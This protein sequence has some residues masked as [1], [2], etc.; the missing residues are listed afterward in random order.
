MK[1]PSL[2][3]QSL[4]QISFLMSVLWVGHCGTT[5]PWGVDLLLEL[6]YTQSEQSLHLSSHP[7]STS[8]T[9]QNYTLLIL[10]QAIMFYF[11]NENSSFFFNQALTWMCDVN[12]GFCPFNFS[13]HSSSTLISALP[14]LFV[15]RHVYVPESSILVPR[16]SNTT[17]PKAWTVLVRWP[18]T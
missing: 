15:A 1:Y 4:T 17:I 2:Q 11:C 12:C 3:S 18:T 7:N 5:P 10:T 8:K 9:W 14:H 6:A 13:T 16:I